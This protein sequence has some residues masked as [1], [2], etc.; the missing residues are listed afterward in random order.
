MRQ[1]TL[2]ILTSAGLSLTHALPAFTQASPR[3]IAGGS[4][5]VEWEDR[6]DH[7]TWP[8]Y[9]LELQG[10]IGKALSRATAL[11]FE[12][13]VT[14]YI[15]PSVEYTVLCP[16]SGCVFPPTYAWVGGRL[17]PTFE[18]VAP[19]EENALF[20]DVMSDVHWFTQRPPGGHTI[21]PDFGG[22]VGVQLGSGR[23]SPRLGLEGHR[24]TSAGLGPKWL[25]GVSLG[26]TR[27]R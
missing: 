1:W 8:A 13:A 19:L 5:G 2:S 3:T 23:W 15:T 7:E 22:R 12:A 27:R 17:G 18:L 6:R 11:L 21:T 16:P 10:H 25:V 20:V 9:G 26:L 4:L 24:L 14:A